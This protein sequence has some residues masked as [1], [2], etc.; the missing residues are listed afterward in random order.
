M[1]DTR[2]RAVAC[3]SFSWRQPAVGF[4]HEL[5]V[6]DAQC[7]DPALLAQ[8]QPDEEAQLDQLRV[9][10]VFVQLLPQRVVGQRGL[11]D[12]GAGIGERGLLALGELIG[13]G[14]V[15]QLGVLRLWN[16]PRSRPDRS[17]RPSILAL[18]GLRDVDAAQLL[19]VVVEYALAEGG[20]P[21]L[22]EGADDGRHM[23]ANRLALG[24]W[25]AMDA[26]ILQ[27]F[28]DFGVGDGG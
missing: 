9:A 16:A 27:V 22:R 26:G 3:Q 14:V 20:H 12:D 5:V 11:P 28:E 17:L 8:R 24:P 7:L 10:E 19:E 15:Q 1:T 25:R 2:L 21:G 4:G 23:R 6:A 13:V 18:D